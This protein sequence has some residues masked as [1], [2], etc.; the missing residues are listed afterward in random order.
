MARCAMRGVWQR[1]RANPGTCSSVLLRAPSTQ[2]QRLATRRNDWRA[3]GGCAA[4]HTL[5]PSCA[6]AHAGDDGDDTAA[7]KQRLPPTLSSGEGHPRQTVFTELASAA[8]K[9]L[10]KCILH[11]NIQDAI[12]SALAC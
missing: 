1:R 10:Q 6:G 5:A 2:L 12:E 9:E 4:I 7:L 3:R 11:G 8:T